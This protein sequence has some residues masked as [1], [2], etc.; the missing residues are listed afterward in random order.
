M[1]INPETPIDQTIEN[2]QLIS[3]LLADDLDLLTHPFV[4]RFRVR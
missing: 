1:F 4:S 2:L 3:E